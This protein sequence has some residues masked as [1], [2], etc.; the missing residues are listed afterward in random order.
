MF[1]SK[2]EFYPLWKVHSWSV[3]HKYVL[4]CRYWKVHLKGTDFVVKVGLCLPN[5]VCAIQWHVCNL[6]ERRGCFKYKIINGYL[7][8]SKHVHV[9]KQLCHIEWKI[10]SSKVNDKLNIF[11][12][13][14]LLSLLSYWCLGFG[15]SCMGTFILYSQTT[16]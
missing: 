2:V 3:T 16:F 13:C 15:G 4:L 12:F 10:T 11:C 8:I 5:P 6:K 1:G 9:M 14:N 7:R